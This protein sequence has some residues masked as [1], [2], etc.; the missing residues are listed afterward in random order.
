MTNLTEL[1]LYVNIEL[2]DI[3]PLAFEPDITNLVEWYHQYLRPD[4]AGAFEYPLSVLMNYGHE[5]LEQ[6][7]KVHIGTVHSFKGGKCDAMYLFPDLSRVAL[8][9]WMSGC[10]E[11]YDA[12]VRTFYVGM[13][14]P[15]QELHLCS[16]SSRCAVDWVL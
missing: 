11:D 5:A 14:R 15:R 12:V 2:T 4:R 1:S 13:T 6:E 8:S 3:S 9:G 10:G 7:P 16:R